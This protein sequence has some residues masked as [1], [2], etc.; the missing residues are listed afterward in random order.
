MPDNGWQP[1]A[2]PYLWAFQLLSIQNWHARRGG[3]QNKKKKGLISI[4]SG[5]G[6]I[7]RPNSAKI[8]AITQMLI[9]FFFFFLETTPLGLPDFWSKSRDKPWKS[10]TYGNPIHRWHQYLILC[11]NSITTT[12][13]F[14]IDRVVPIGATF[15]WTI[16]TFCATWEGSACHWKLL[17]VPSVAR[18]P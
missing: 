17:G 3:L 6:A 10:R 16:K 13:L 18:V 9:F 8:S 12:G 11:T 14:F 1:C 2:R 15:V 7:H 4:R 5:F